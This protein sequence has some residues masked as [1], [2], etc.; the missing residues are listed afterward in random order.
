MRL[1]SSNFENFPFLTM[2]KGTNCI[3]VV[4][5]GLDFFEI[6]M[7]VVYD[8]RATLYQEIAFQFEHISEAK[9]EY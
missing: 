3:G 4:G 9:H 5:G 6:T 1:Q 7:C 8:K 2:N